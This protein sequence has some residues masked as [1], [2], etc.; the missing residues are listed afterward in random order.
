[1]GVWFAGRG[2][3]GALVLA[4]VV[5]P[6]GIAVVLRPV[7]YD[8]LRQFLFVMPALACLVGL[9]LDAVLRLRNAGMRSVGIGLLACSMVLTAGEMASLHP[10]QAIYFNRT[11]GGGLERAAKGFETDYWG[12]SYKEAVRWLIAEHRPAGARRLRVA[13]VSNHFLTAY[14]LNKPG[15]AR[16]R[17]EPVVQP[18]RADVVLATTRWNLHESWPGRVLHVVTRQGVG[19]CYVIERGG[20]QSISRSTLG[21]RKNISSPASPGP[22]ARSTSATPPFLKASEPPSLAPTSRASSDER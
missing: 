7:I 12:S 20:A 8:G 9:G 3:K 4:S 10:Y 19:L 6:I 1:V 13:N 21:G 18:K 17:F 2:W 15:E 22:P 11:I 14:Y 16:A 5:A